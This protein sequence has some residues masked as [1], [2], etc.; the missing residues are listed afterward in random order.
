MAARRIGAALTA[1]AAV[2]FGLLDLA[3]WNLPHLTLAA[4]AYV[5]LFVAVGAPGTALVTGLT[6]AM[7]QAGGSGRR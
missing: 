4:P 5:A 3:V 7:R 6:S 1:W 2:A